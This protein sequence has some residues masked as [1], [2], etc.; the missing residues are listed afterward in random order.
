MVQ[1]IVVRTGM[2]DGKA[3][4]LV[5][6]ASHVACTSWGIEEREFCVTSQRYCTSISPLG[7]HSSSKVPCP[8]PEPS[9]G[10]QVFKH[11][12]LRETY[13]IQN[14]TWYPCV[15]GVVLKGKTS[16]TCLMM[17]CELPKTHQTSRCSDLDLQASGFSR[18]VLGIEIPHF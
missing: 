18:S 3:Q 6:V 4:T 12:S 2:E 9:L 17:G 7:A 1:S 8:K 5:V 11:A 15:S 14:V 16:H 13:L 10:G